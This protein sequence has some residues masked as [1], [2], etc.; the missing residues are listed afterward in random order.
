MGDADRFSTYDVYANILLN[1]GRG[2]LAKAQGQYDQAVEH[3]DQALKAGEDAR[4]LANKADCLLMTN[5]LYRASEAIQQAIALTPDD[6][7]LYVLR[8]KLNKM[9]FN[10]SD[11][12]RDISL[13]VEHGLDRE[14]VD[15]LLK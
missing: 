12:N 8:A 9:R 4:L 6:P 2:L 1:E 14:L 13:A 3:F 7:Y 15:Q 11:M 10:T 5:Q